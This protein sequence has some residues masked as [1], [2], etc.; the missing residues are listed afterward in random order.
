MRFEYAG[1]VLPEE[2]PLVERFESDV[3]PYIQKHGSEIGDA[4]MKGNTTAE[5][6]IRRYNLF[7]NGMPEFRAFHLKLM[8]AALKRWGSM[9]H[10]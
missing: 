6:V 10:N 9:T 7:L 8:I 1:G 3:L 2:R 4:A 5:E